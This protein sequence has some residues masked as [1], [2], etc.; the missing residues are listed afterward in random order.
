MIEGEG[1]GGEDREREY[2]AAENKGGK[3]EHEKLAKSRR[4]SSTVGGGW[5]LLVGSLFALSALNANNSAAKCRN[6]SFGHG[7]TFS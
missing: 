7:G 1:G 6:T 4:G 5:R 2:E 3:G